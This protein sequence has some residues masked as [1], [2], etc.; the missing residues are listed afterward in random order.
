MA[1]IELDII[2]QRSEKL[3]AA[4]KVELINYL[5]ASLTPDEI[6]QTK[7]PTTSNEHN[8][9]SNGKL[10]DKETGTRSSIFNF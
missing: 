3:L 8:D 1:T 2:K 7:D 4:E 5:A 6:A 9:V 10:S